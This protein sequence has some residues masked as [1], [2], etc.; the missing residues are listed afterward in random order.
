MAA[1][2]MNVWAEETIDLFSV[3]RA[4]ILKNVEFIWTDRML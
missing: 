4:S 3:N 2:I 1:D